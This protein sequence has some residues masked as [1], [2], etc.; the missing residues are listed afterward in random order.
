MIDDNARPRVPAQENFDQDR[1][2]F[3]GLG[4]KQRFERI[5][6]T[7][8]WGA[9]TSPS[10]LGSEPD[11]TTVLARDL[12]QLLERLKVRSLLDAPCGDAS[13][14]GRVALPVSYIGV[15]IVPAIIDRLQAQGSAE[16]EFRHGD[17][18]T[19]QLPAADAI[20]CRDCLVHLSFA[21]IKRAIAN[22]KRSGSV[23][24][25]VTTF[26]QL[27]VNRDIEDGDWRPLNFCAA[28]F[29]WPEPLELLSEQCT[30]ADGFYHDKSLGVWRLADIAG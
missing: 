28:P 9:P 26:A 1:A 19:D 21:N 6:S 15:D 4:L 29:N 18:T 24:L 11:Q 13:W 27:K 30:E 23:Y 8:L 5:F 10:G 3:T 25:M 20:L 2:A 22:F 14:I 7:N 12:P 16:R 17:I